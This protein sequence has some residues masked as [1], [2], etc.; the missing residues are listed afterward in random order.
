MRRRASGL[1]LKGFIDASIEVIKVGIYGYLGILILMIASA[2]I[3]TI[4]NEIK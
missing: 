3:G 4:N 1:R 2:R